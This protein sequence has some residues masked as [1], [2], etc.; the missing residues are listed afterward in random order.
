MQKKGMKYAEKCKNMQKQAT[1]YAGIRRNHDTPKY[2]TIYAEIC[3][4][5]DSSSKNMQKYAQNMKE[6]CKYMQ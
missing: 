3:K 5:K 1:K 4:N 6:M 2:A